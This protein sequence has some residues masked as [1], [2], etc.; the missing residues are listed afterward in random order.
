MDFMKNY[1]KQLSTTVKNKK[2]EELVSTKDV[3]DHGAMSDV[4]TILKSKEHIYQQLMTSQLQEKN[5]LKIKKEVIYAT[6]D[7]RMDNEC[8]DPL[9]KKINDMSKSELIREC[10][11]IKD[12]TIE[13]KND[14]ESLVEDIQLA[15]NNTFDT[16]NA[17]MNDL[18]R[19]FQ[20]D[21]LDIN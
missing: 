10:N 7:K 19:K 1:S 8:Q 20:L 2:D 3:V 5:I 9:Q 13:L 21:N 18:K 16:I 6:T 11:N 15:K 12:K 4:N 17:I 14:S